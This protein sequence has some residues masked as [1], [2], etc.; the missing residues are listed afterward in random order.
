MVPR[1]R[2]ETVKDWTSEDPREVPAE[3]QHLEMKV[4]AEI[5]NNS[6]MI[7]HWIFSRLDFWVDPH[8]LKLYTSTCPNLPTAHLQEESPLSGS[9]IPT[10]LAATTAEL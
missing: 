2:L 10:Q 9:V 3:K 1:E 8:N 5:C 6:F 7:I 4:L